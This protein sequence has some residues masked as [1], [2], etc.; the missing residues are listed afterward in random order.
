MNEVRQK[1]LKYVEE[2]KRLMEEKRLKHYYGNSDNQN[3]RFKKDIEKLKSD[4]KSK[5]KQLVRMNNDTNA[6]NNK[7]S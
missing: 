7:R 4:L 6:I 3:K 1:W 5:Y 2:N